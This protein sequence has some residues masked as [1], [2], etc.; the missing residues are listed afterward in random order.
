LATRWEV[1]DFRFTSGSDDSRVSNNNIEFTLAT[2][3][4]F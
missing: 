1:R 4:L 2:N 3:F